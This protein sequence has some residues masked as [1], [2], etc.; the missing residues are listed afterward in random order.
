MRESIA[1]ESSVVSLSVDNTG[2]WFVS[3]SSIELSALVSLVDASRSLVEKLLNVGKAAADVDPV[4]EP[5]PSAV[6]NLL[7]AAGG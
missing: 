5:S 7:A 6:L 1:R 2:C 4:A 3:I